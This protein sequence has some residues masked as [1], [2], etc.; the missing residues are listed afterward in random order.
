MRES[1]RKRQLQKLQRTIV[2]GLEDVR[3]REICVYN[4]E[5]LSS[6]FERVI[7]ASGNTSRQT[8]AMANSVQQKLQAA[9]FDK[10]RLEGEGEGEWIIVDCGAA[11]VHLMQPAVRQYYRLEEI[12][13]GK[14]V[15][16][17]MAPES[18]PIGQG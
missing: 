2:D 10:P 8:R 15:R 13:G 6:L 1:A 16:M 11:V 17:R 12:W 4:T 9:G 14:V 18:R 5:A 3:A 7:I